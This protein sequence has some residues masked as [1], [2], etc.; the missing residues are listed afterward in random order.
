M[1][2]T[3]KPQYVAYIGTH[4][5]AAAARFVVWGPLGLVDVAP[6]MIEAVRAARAALR[7][8]MPVVTIY[9]HRRT[10]TGGA[11]WAVAADIFA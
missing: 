8:R 3:A 11:E 7:E 1:N 2:A 4:R 9:E 5:V 10:P 6:T